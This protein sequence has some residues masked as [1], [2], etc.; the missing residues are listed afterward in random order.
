MQ[1]TKVKLGL[2]AMALTITAALGVAVGAL[3]VTDATPP[4]LATAPEITAAPITQQQFSDQRTVEVTLTSGTKTSLTT[5]RAGRVTRVDCQPGAVLNSGTSSLAIDSAP[6]VSLATTVPLW[7]DL[8]PGDRG[9]DVTALH[10]EL[11]RLGHLVTGDSVTSA[12][13]QAITA[14]LRAAGETGPISGVP[15]ERIMWL[16]AAQTTVE[17]C[18]VAL[19]SQVAAHA[20]IA[21][22][23]GGLAAARI[24]LLPTDAAPGPRVLLVD[25]QSIAVSA[26]GVVTDLAALA[27]TSS[28]QQ[29]SHGQLGALSA[30]YVL[31]EPVDA[32]VVPPAAL[33]Q[34]D[35]TAACLASEPAPVAVQVVGSELG[36]SFVVA[37]GETTPETA[38]L[39]PNEDASC[40]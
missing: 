35:G 4:Q 1:P 26:D 39:T 24:A 29:A 30:S 21:T 23:P 38:L 17:S 18:G 13:V 32:L 22:L 19:G 5:P 8:Y 31:A 25:G 3:F 12:T 9:E 34:F 27:Q 28:Y 36:R 15:L 7:R 16:P 11:N 2:G 37:E 40:R 20:P 10:A 6:I 33:Y 14:I